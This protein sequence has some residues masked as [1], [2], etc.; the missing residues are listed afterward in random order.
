MQ[1]VP[2]LL[3]VCGQT[4]RNSISIR[5]VI[6]T[7]F[8]SREDQSAHVN[9]RT[10]QNYILFMT[11]RLKRSLLYANP[12]HFR[13]VRIIYEH[14]KTPQGNYLP[15]K[16]RNTF[17][18]ST[19]AHSLMPHE[20]DPIYYVLSILHAFPHRLLNEVPISLL[21]KQPNQNKLVAALH[22]PRKC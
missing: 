22:K 8:S 4:K 5:M 3:Y 21:L 20:T 19:F 2:N 12:S 16:R 15:V 13:G 1:Y 11:N 7:S 17:H 6:G 18:R 9:C 14:R 10:I